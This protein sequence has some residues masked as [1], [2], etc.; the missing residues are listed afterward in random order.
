M[1]RGE[2]R[3]FERGG[4]GPAGL[5]DSFRSPSPV[6]SVGKQPS[7]LTGLW[8]C[9]AP[10]AHVS[11]FW[12]R[13]RPPSAPSPVRG[14]VGW[15]PPTPCRFQ[16]GC[17]LPT[18]GCRETRET[19]EIVGPLKLEAGTG[20]HGGPLTV[21]CLHK[22]GFCHPVSDTLG[23][24]RRFRSEATLSPRRRARWAAGRLCFQ[25]KLCAWG[26]LD[27]GLIHASLFAQPS[28]PHPRS[29]GLLGTEW[30]L[31]ALSGS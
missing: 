9:A 14:P 5:S 10:S 12:P 18:G 17:S 29:P 31:A 4:R 24:Q 20:G 26:L 28:Q 22:R 11:A 21:I 30:G 8:L 6:R 15:A 13:R 19:R 1:F 23:R 7:T 25:M 27:L 2:V 3:V 16:S